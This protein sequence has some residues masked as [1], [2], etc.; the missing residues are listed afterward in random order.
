MK[1]NHSEQVEQ[2]RSA[3][4]QQLMDEFGLSEKQAQEYFD[5]MMLI[6]GEHFNDYVKRKSNGR[7]AYI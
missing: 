3:I 6:C 4:R 2:E 7:T 5:A 1:L